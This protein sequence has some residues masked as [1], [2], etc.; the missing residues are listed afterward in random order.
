MCGRGASLDEP[1][2]GIEPTAYA[3]PRVGWPASIPGASS[4]L[5]VLLVADATEQ[6]TAC[7][8]RLDQ[9]ECPEA[10]QLVVDV[11]GKVG[12]TP[13]PVEPAGLGEVPLR[14]ADPELVMSGPLMRIRHSHRRRSPA[15]GPI[16]RSA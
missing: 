12:N 8:R 3:L 7:G 6:V 15:S 14:P 13:V 11:D 9:E 16:R 2:V 1:K 10:A 5:G 4:D